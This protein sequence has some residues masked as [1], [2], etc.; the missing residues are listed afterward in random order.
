M[1]VWPSWP[2]P[3]IR[4]GLGGLPAE[5]VVLRHGQRIH[6]GPQAH[7][8]PHAGGTDGLAGLLALDD[9]DHARLADTGVH[10][11]H[12][13]QLECMHHAAGGVDL[14]KAEFRVGVQVAPEGGQL[15]MELRDLRKGPAAGAQRGRVARLVASAAPASVELNCLEGPKGLG[16]W[17]E[18]ACQ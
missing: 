6:V 8:G 14:F 4:P 10:F 5:F 12:T 16:W 1:V 9:G 18:H 11:I 3:C 15:G 7:H 13:A 2:Q 17:P